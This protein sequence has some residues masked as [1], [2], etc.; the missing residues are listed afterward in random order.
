MT[1]IDSFTSGWDSIVGE[2]TYLSS[3][4]GVKFLAVGLI[5]ALILF[6]ALYISRALGTKITI[7]HVIAFVVISAA[8]AILL[9]DWLSLIDWL[10]LGLSGQSVGVTIWAIG[11]IAF[12]AVLAY[13]AITTHGRYL[14]R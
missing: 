11:E 10:A 2:G 9:Q 3:T 13:N 7:Y 5:V 8:V 6:G 12:V 4:G 14:V 1:L